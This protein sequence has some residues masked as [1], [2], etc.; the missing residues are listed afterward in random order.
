[1]NFENIAVTILCQVYAAS[2]YK[3]SPTIWARNRR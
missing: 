3:I 2:T 1:L